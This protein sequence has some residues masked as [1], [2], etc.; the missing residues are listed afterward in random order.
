MDI[1]VCCFFF[2]FIP[3]C[4]SSG[5]ISPN[6]SAICISFDWELKFIGISNTWYGITVSPYWIIF[7][8]IWPEPPRLFVPF[9]GARC[10]NLLI[11]I[12]SS[13]SRCGWICVNFYQ[14]SFVSS[15]QFAIKRISCKE[16]IDTKLNQQPGVCP[17]AHF[18]THKQNAMMKIRQRIEI[19]ET[20]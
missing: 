19:S 15:N 1:F 9:D 10:K 2:C 12:N 14:H 7:N 13:V 17:S 20:K 8:S 5:C 18:Q 6:E 16:I 11:L 3:P 4:P